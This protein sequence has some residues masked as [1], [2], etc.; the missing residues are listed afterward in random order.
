MI[1]YDADGEG[2]VESGAVAGVFDVVGAGGADEIVG[3][4][5]PAGEDVRVLA[6]AG[7][8]FVEDDVAHGVAA[9][10]TR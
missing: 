8:V 7:S 1:T 5:T 9:I 4:G 10:P 2:D 3:E 6:D